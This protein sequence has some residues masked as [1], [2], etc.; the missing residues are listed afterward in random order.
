MNNKSPEI[1]A[2]VEKIFPQEVLLRIQGRIISYPRNLLPAEI[3]PGQT[4]SF[5]IEPNKH[6]YHRQHQNLNNSKNSE[7]AMYK[8]MQ[9]ALRDL[10]K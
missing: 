7:E 1:T 5:H 9:R 10:I 2:T 3:K 4:F 8:A 6:K